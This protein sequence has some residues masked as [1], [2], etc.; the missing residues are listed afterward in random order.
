SDNQFSNII[1]A[2]LAV[3]DWSSISFDSWNFWPLTIVSVIG[4]FIFV[5]VLQNVIISYMGAAF[6]DAVENSKR[7]VYGF[8]IELIY[9]FALLKSLELN[10]LDYK[11]N[12]KLRAKYICFYDDPSITSGYDNLSIENCKFIWEPANEKENDF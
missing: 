5:L 12:D 4:S 3:Y 7:G 2:I 11:F 1:G 10:N 6:S 8:Q 9:D